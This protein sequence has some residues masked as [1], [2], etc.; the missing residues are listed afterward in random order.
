MWLHVMH[1]LGCIAF[2]VVAWWLWRSLAADRAFATIVGIGAAVRAVV[3]IALFAISFFRLPIATSLQLG[4]GFWFYAPDA[5]GYFEFAERAASQGW[6]AIASLGSGLPSVV[7]IQVLAAMMYFVGPTPSAALLLNLLSYLGT[8]AIVVAWSRRIGA[9]RRTTAF[10]LIAVSAFPSW[11]LWSAQPL[12]DTFFLFLM[13]AYPFVASRW[14]DAP[15]GRTSRDAATV[16][17]MLALLLYLAT[18]IRW[19]V[20]LLMAGGTVL[21]WGVDAAR[22]PAPRAA[23]L[24][25][26]AVF[27]LVAA[28][29]IPVSAG[30]AMPGFGRLLFRPN[31]A[32]DVL[33]APLRAAEYLDDKRV[34]SLA[35]VADTTI[36]RPAAD[37]LAG[38][39]GRE[40][41]PARRRDIESGERSLSL[42]ERIFPRA[43]AMFL[44]RFIGTAFG[45]IE[46]GGGR[47]LWTMAEADTVFL[48][49][50]LVAVAYLLLR[51]RPFSAGWSPMLLYVGA[52]TVVLAL[53]VCYQTANFGTQFRL[54]SMVA[55][56]FLLLLLTSAPK[57]YHRE[58]H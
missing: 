42:F 4:G 46:I 40:E 24:T 26:I 35:T 56:G 30:S 6:S 18:G 47:G 2:G 1:L 10:I 29:V 31:S 11:I 36:R 7:Y 28:I 5:V 16:I 44:P 58:P 34:D 39:S 55:V 17:G 14:T 13:V 33:A 57:A 32:S 21:A 41:G 8:C 12:K 3:G 27:V 19:Y 51:R 52:T 38:T 49:A 22:R 54:R 45:W 43:V 50:I 15:I 25:P 37:A 23:Q 48:D 20:G 9:E 53:A